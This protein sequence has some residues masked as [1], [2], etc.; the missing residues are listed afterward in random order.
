MSSAG[1][2]GASGTGG[3]GLAGM[4]GNP[5]LPTWHTGDPTTSD[6]CLDSHW[7]WGQCLDTTAGVNP[8]QAP[9]CPG[10]YTVMNCAGCRGD[11]GGF[12]KS[13]DLTQTD[14]FY[15]AGSLGIQASCFCM[16]GMTGLGGTGGSAGAGGS[17]G[18]LPHFQLDQIPIFEVMDPAVQSKIAS[19][20]FRVKFEIDPPWQV[21]YQIEGS[22]S[23][24]IAD[25]CLEK[26]GQCIDLPLIGY[27]IGVPSSPFRIVSLLTT[28]SP[29]VEKNLHI[30]I[31]DPSVEAGCP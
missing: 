12:F 23:N 17:T 20:Q 15:R 11:V 19:S 30:R 10:I 16:A 4:A 26:Q 8:P 5:N 31:Y 29:T 6:P 2:A 28:G 13:L 7:L 22:S 3:M 27:I 1:A 21:T 14:F 24:D 25:E 9:G 18:E